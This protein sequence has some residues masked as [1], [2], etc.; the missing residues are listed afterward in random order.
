MRFTFF[1]QL[2][3]ALLLLLP[4]PGN[5][6]TDGRPGLHSSGQIFIR[7][8]F[9]QNVQVSKLRDI[10]LVV[11]DDMLSNGIE[12]IQEFCVRGSRNGY[13]RLVAHSDRGG[14]TPFSLHGDSGE[15]VNFN[16]YF[17]GDLRSNVLEPM[18]PGIPSQNYR[19]Q[20]NG[21]DCNGE[22]NAS[23][24]IQIP[25]HELRNKTSQEFSGYLSLTVA[26]E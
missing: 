20:S 13:Y 17:N 19:V 4:L 5:S 9:N 16:L 10:E 24:A 6:A 1:L 26:I 7:L 14:S 12:T 11:D 21:V 15:N 18:V 2:L 3:P 22:D 23:I 25:P 8:Q